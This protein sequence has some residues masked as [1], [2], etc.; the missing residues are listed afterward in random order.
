MD[1]WPEKKSGQPVSGIWACK[2]VST[3]LF[4]TLTKHLN[5]ILQKDLHFSGFRSTSQHLVE[6]PEA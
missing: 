2:I 6:I 4:D 5:G 3:T 1:F